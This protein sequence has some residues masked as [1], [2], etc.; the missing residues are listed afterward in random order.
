MTKYEYKVLKF[1][2]KG[3]MGGQID[4]EEMERRLNSLGAEGWE[5]IRVTP[6]LI[7]MGRTRLLVATMKRPVQ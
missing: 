4:D 5:L 6:I 2:M 7:D 1:D 3:W